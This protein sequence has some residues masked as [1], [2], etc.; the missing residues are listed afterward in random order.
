MRKPELKG[1]RG[2][3]F[4]RDR[5]RRL[6][7]CPSLSLKRFQIDGLRGH[8]VREALAAMEMFQHRS[9]RTLPNDFDSNFRRTALIRG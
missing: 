8:C 5:R 7:Q 9:V 2:S 1:A 4:S 3:G 6:R